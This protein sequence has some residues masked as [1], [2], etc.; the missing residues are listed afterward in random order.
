MSGLIQRSA[1]EFITAA[2]DMTL[3]VSFPGLVASRRQSEMR[4]D[5]T[6]LS[7]TVR[8]INRGAECQRGKRPRSY[9]MIPIWLRH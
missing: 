7:K 4:T 1:S 6:G 5:V 8:L 9:V 3:Y 2:A